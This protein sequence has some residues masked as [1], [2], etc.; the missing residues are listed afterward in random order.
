[1]S[2]HETRKRKRRGVILEEGEIKEDYSQIQ[3]TEEDDELSKD[4]YLLPDGSYIFVEIN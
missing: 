4:D 2:K 3:E 1:M